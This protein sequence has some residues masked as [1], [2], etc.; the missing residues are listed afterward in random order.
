M[1]IRLRRA[2]HSRSTPIRNTL[3]AASLIARSTAARTPAAAHAAK[4]PAARTAKS[5]DCSKQA[6]AEVLHGK[7]RKGFMSS[8]KGA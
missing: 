2:G 4:V 5:L 6:D 7:P 1:C 3:A 8:C